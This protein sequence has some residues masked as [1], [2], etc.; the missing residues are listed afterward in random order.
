MSAEDE[1][2]NCL[3]DVS[4]LATYARSPSMMATISLSDVL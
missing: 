4:N 3:Q 2:S 1:K